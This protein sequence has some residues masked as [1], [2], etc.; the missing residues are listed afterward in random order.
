M[1]EE[2]RG[3]PVE[4]TEPPLDSVAEG[5]LRRELEETWYVPKGFLGWFRVVDHRTI[6]LRYITT[7]FCFFIFAG[8]LAA[9]MRIQLAVP[10][11]HFLGPDL[12]NQ[13]FTTHGTMMMFLFAVPVME[14]MGIYLVPLMV[15]ARNIAFPRLNAY[16]YYVFLFGGV[17][18]V[19]TMLMNTAPDA[20]WFAYVPLSGPDYTPGKR[21]DFWAQLITFTEVAGLA[22]AVELVATIFK[23]RAPGRR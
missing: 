23:C 2:Q 8:I 17:M 10:N 7:A 13:V 6:G 15:G 20:G 22:V 16:S 14:A 11:N 9:L 18:L 12:Y 21:S 19:M 1:H 3:E 4:R 5:R